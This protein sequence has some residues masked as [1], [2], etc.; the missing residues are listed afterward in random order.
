MC[1]LSS[2]SLLAM[3][4]KLCRQLL[5]YLIAFC[6]LDNPAELWIARRVPMCDDLQTWSKRSR[7]HPDSGFLKANEIDLSA[8]GFEAPNQT[9]I[10]N[11]IARSEHQQT[12]ADNQANLARLTSDQLKIFDAIIRSTSSSVEENKVMFVDAP[13][14]TGKSYILNCTI[15]QC[16]LDGHNPIAVASSGIAA[17]LLTN[18]KTAHFTFKISLEAD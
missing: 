2:D 12:T 17:L 1:W 6:T 3:Y 15:H 5:G 9:E 18:G 14:G 8:F 13:G 10:E 11:L 7:R 16:S 4:A